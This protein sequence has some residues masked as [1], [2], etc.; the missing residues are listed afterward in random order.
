VDEQGVTIRGDGRLKA[1]ECDVCKQPF[2][3]P[4]FWDW[5]NIKDQIIYC[6]V[7]AGGTKRNDT[8]EQ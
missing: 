3:D 4:L 7:R 6:K 1:P 8:I 5:H 2:K